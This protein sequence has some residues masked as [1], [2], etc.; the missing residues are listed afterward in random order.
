MA[1]P[2][3]TLPRVTPVI[4]VARTHPFDDPDWLFEPKFDGFRAIL[5]IDGASAEFSSKRGRPL[6]RFAR[7]ASAIRARLGAGRVVLDGEVVAL[8]E[9]GR[10]NFIHLMAGQGEL[11]YAAFD[12]LWLGGTDLRPL[13]LRERRARLAGL[14][15]DTSPLLS[16]IFGAT[17][18]GRDLFQVV[19][20]MDLEGIV[21]KRLDDPYGPETVWYKIKNRGYTQMTPHRFDRVPRSR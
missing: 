3:S 1:A 11:H 12:L 13:P 2:V 18:C 5:C 6:K 4:P 9:Q 20:L 7:L 19:K 16:H 8:D 10:V 17:E 15:G 21:A 14:I